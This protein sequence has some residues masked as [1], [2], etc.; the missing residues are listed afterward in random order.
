MLFIRFPSITVTISIFLCIMSA[1]AQPHRIITLGG[2]IT[3]TV[4]ALG[5]EDRIVAVDVTSEYPESIKKLPKV[6]KNRSV[7]AEG[8]MA[9]RPDLVLAPYGDVPYSVVQALKGAGIPFV[10]IK[11]DFSARGALAFIRDVG[12]A[13]GMK[14]Q[15]SQLATETERRIE[16]VL[17]TVEASDKRPTVLFIYARGTGT[18]TVAG[19]GSNMDALIRL[20]GGR[21]AIR[22]FNAFKTYTTEALVHANPDIILLFDFGME[23]LG[24]RKG[25]LGMPGV[26][27]TNAGKHQRIVAL[28]GP[29]MIS[30][31]TRLD[32][33][34]LRVHQEFIK[35]RE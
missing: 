8:L 10:A 32:E 19:K 13:L 7:S 12:K 16:E 3:E 27:F 31:S 30:F 21:N 15:A 6:S 14:D 2:A 35:T 1:N 17:Q 34:I 18:M 23:S 24:G 9:F 20:A 26:A 11:Q 33:A 4:A 22:E 28:D 5:L 29:L 25:V